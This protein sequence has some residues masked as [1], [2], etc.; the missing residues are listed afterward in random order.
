M[1]EVRIVESLVEDIKKKF[2]KLEAHKIFDLMESL[3]NSPHKGKIIGPVGG[4]VIKELKY[5]NFRFYFITD[6]INLKFTNEADLVDMLL[7]FVRMS[8]KKHQQKVLEEIKVVLKTL[9]PEG[10]ESPQPDIRNCYACNQQI[11]TGVTGCS[12]QKIEISCNQK[13]V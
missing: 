13:P 3:G 12:L 7:K 11:R 2:N 6:G 4:I 5:R 1:I 10:F 9:G 8:D